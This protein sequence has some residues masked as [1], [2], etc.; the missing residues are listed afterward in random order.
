VIDLATYAAT[1]AKRRPLR[2]E[3]RSGTAVQPALSCEI[4]LR[5]SLRPDGRRHSR[6]QQPDVARIDRLRRGRR[7]RDGFGAA[8]EQG[9]RQS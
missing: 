5:R 3:V 2:V 6:R 8:D 7:R 4:R 9:H 1:A